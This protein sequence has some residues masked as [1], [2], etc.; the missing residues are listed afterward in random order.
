MASPRP[1]VWYFFSDDLPDG[2]LI[3]PIV[4]DEHGLAFAVRPNAGMD[5]EMLDRLNQA[6]DHVLSIGIIHLG[7]SQAGKPPDGR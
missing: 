1:R 4:S 6:A 5:K 2:E 7:S 3:V